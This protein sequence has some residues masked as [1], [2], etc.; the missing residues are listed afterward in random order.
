MK[1]IADFLAA[2]PPF[3]L[4]D[5]EALEEVA[6]GVNVEYHL[7]GSVVREAVGDEDHV[8]VVR[9]GRVELLDENGLVVDE[10]GPG[11]VLGE[12][13]GGFAVRRVA[14]A[15]ED[16]LTY[17]VE[18]PPQLLA[19]SAGTRGPTPLTFP[20]RLLDPAHRGVTEFLRPLVLHPADSTVREVAL[21]MTAARTSCCVVAMPDG[22]LGV[23]TDDDL[24]RRVATGDVPLDAPVGVLAS[25]PA[26][27]VVEGSS[28][29]DAYVAMVE[30]AIHHLVILDADGRPL[31]VV[32]VV[33][34]A[35]AELRNPLVARAAI[36][37][38]TTSQHLVEAGRLIHPSVVELVQRNVATEYVARLQSTVVEAFLRRAIELTVGGTG[39]SSAPTWFVL[40]SIARREPLPGSDVDTA[41]SWTSGVERSHR[42]NASAVLDLVEE[43]GLMRCPQG[44]NADQPLFSRSAEAWSA[45][46]TSWLANPDEAG[47][48]ILASIVADSRP[49]T[50][51]RGSSVLTDAVEKASRHEEFL[52]ILAR[53]AL[54]R[55]PPLGFVRDFVVEHSGRHRGSLDLKRGGLLPVTSM[56]RWLSLRMG[57]VDG[58]TSERL[59][60]ACDAGLLKKDE[61]DMLVGAFDVAFRLLV[62]QQ[63]RA[64]AEGERPP[65]ILKPAELDPLTRRQLREAFRAIASVQATVGASI[66]LRV[67]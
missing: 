56:A 53:H 47:A 19:A 41:L 17:A 13:P 4:L 14:R 43:A 31:G 36:D 30:H 32:R 54:S 57:V 63:A 52:Q 1:E 49:I 44:A 8:L 45:S 9:V 20:E 12:E 18:L 5:R 21:A 66:G 10:A 28:L 67:P 37:N 26:R 51:S 48:L 38:A 6:G 62:S 46:A 33:D 34:V 15:A 7:A 42:E 23:V 59:R 3:D 22:V 55:R 35:A 27:T 40:G 2:Y 60:R 61:A 29:A 24:R 11:D 16:T 58:T 39:T 65:T 50:G 25:L 64:L